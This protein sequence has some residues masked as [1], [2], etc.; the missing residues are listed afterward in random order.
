MNTSE[1][2]ALLM[3]RPDLLLILDAIQIRLSEAAS[4]RHEFRQ[5]LDEDKKAVEGFEISVAALFDETA[6]TQ[7]MIALTNA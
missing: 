6:C 1:L 2:I 4:R 5:W 7:A 3:K